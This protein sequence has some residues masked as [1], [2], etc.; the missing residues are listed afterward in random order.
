MAQLL[1]FFQSKYPPFTPRIRPISAGFQCLI[2]VDEMQKNHHVFAKINSW[3]LGKTWKSHTLKYHVK[4]TKQPN[5][6]IHMIL[7]CKTAISQ[8]FSGK[9]ASA[10]GKSIPSMTLRKSPGEFQDFPARLPLQS[11][12]KSTN[13]PASQSKTKCKVMLKIHFPSFSIIFHHVPSCS[14]IFHHVSSFSMIFHHLPSENQHFGICFGC[15]PTISWPFTSFTKALRGTSWC[16]W[17]LAHRWAPPPRLS[18]CWCGT[19]VLPKMDGQ[20]RV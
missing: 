10:I 15:S 16:A 9:M 7:P 1:I 3:F 11:P 8:Y 17:A 19:A 6:P 18:S 5:F 13:F 20:W 14:I 2:A 12:L 4:K